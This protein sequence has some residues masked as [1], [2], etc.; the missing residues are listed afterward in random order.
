[1]V[2]DGNGYANCNCCTWNNP[3][4]LSK[5]TGRL[6]NQRTIKDRPYRLQFIKMSRNTEK[7]PRDVK[8]LDSRESQAANCQNGTTKSR[9]D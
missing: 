8:K 1:M 3:Q 7:S 6:R 9:Q 4:R 2:H 5:G